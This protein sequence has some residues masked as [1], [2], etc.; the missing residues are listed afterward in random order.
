MR[1]LGLY[2]AFVS[3]EQNVAARAADERAAE[4]GDAR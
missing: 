4:D 1:E 2:D 3:A